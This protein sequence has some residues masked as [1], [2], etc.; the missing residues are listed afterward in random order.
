[1]KKL[2][3]KLNFYMSGICPYCG[4]KSYDRDEDSCT[5]CG[6]GTDRE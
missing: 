5:S 4:E 2:F 3:K 1:M 6:Y